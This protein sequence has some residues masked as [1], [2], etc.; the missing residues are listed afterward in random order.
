MELSQNFNSNCYKPITVDTTNNTLSSQSLINTV[1]DYVKQRRGIDFHAY[2][3]SMIERRLI[4]RMIQSHAP[5]LQTYLS[6]LED[7]DE[8]DKLISYLTIKVSQFLRD[9]RTFNIISS[10]VIPEIIR[11]KEAN[12][13]LRIW[14]AGC[15]FGEEAYSIAL[16]LKQSVSPEV[17]ERVEIIATD[18]DEQALRVAAA[19]NYP[20]RYL[21]G[22]P[23]TTIAND[24]SCK[25]NG[26]EIEYSIADDYKKIVRFMQHDL[27]TAKTGPLGNI[28]F[29]LV[30]CRN[31]QIYLHRSVQERVQLLLRN[32]LMPNGYLC[33]GKAEWLVPPFYQDFIVVDRL[34]RIFYRK[35]DSN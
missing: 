27:V 3:Q 16:V 34:A 24:F 25:H 2:R 15:G 9:P 28:S 11:R 13:H 29:D 30:L 5:D 31:V 10:Q 18:I 19:G 32:H 8:I 4:G 17:Y 23:F 6:F 33:F 20:T 22:L 12:E 7:D 26:S 35:D 14:S 21:K 1:L